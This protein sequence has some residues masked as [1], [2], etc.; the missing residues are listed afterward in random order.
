MRPKSLRPRLGYTLAE[1]ML[2][3]LIIALIALVS[4]PYLAPALRQ[5]TLDRAAD[6]LVGRFATV[7]AQAI[8]GNTFCQITFN[9]GAGT[10]S[11]QVYD[12]ESGQWVADGVQ[13]R[14]PNRVTFS[15]SGVTFPNRVATFDPH[16]SLREGGS[17]TIAGPSGESVVLVGVL[18][19]GRLVRAEEV[20]S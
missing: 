18:A 5:S 10:Y 17:I 1:V 7:R 4:V 11:V 16:G 15:G 13:H 12:P 2:V 8:A 14:L 20:G 6:E 9:E 19:T 3:V